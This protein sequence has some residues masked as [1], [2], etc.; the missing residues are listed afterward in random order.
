MNK[1]IIKAV[2]LV[3]VFLV[4]LV[5]LSL[6]TDTEQVDL[7]SE[8]QEPT[9]PVVCLQKGDTYINE[10]F[11]YKGTMN[12][13][14]VRDTITPLA[15]NMVLPVTIQ[16]YDN[17]IEGISYEVRTLDM[18]RL[19][20]ETQIADFIQTD[21][22]IS[23]EFQI[24]NLLEKEQEYMLIITLECNREK[25]HYY[26]RVICAEDWHV[27]DAIAFTLDFHEKTF[28]KAAASELATYL[29]PSSEGDNTTLQ[30]V[31]IHSSL[32]QITWGD[33]QG[34]VLEKPVPSI[35][36][37]GSSFQTIVLQYV[38]ASNGENGETEFYNVEEYYRLRY[39]SVNNRMLLLN[40]ERTM[41][42]IFRGSGDNFTG[43]GLRLGIREQDVSYMANENATIISFVQEG[44]LWSYNS[45]NNQLSLVYSFRGIEGMEKRTNNQNHDVRIIKVSES[46]GIDFVVY[47]YMNRGEREGCTGIGVYHYDSIANTIQEELFVQSGDAYQVLKETWGKLFYVSGEGYFYMR[48]EGSLYRI[49]LTDGA[50]KL[51][52]TGLDEENFAVSRD[53][54]YVAWRDETN[55][56]IVV[57]DLEGEEQWQIPA[58]A[59]E[60]LRP[61]GFVES[62]FVYGIGSDGENLGGRTLLKKIVI[63]DKN[64][65]VIKEYEKNGYYITDAYV[66][67]STVFLKRVWKDGTFYTQVEGDAIKSHEIEAARSIR[68]ETVA[69]EPKQTQ[70]TLTTDHE[71]SRKVPQVLTPKEVVVEKK[72]VAALDITPEEKNYYVYSGGKVMLCTKKVEEAVQCADTYAGVVLGDKQEYIWNRGRQ[73]SVSMADAVILE[74]EELNNVSGLMARSLTALLQKERISFDVGGLVDAGENPQR[75]LQEAMPSAR[76]LNL[77]GC[78][79]T[80]VLYYVNRGSLV[81]AWGENQEP[82]LIVGYDELNT[83]LY[84]PETNTTYK[85]GIQDSEEFFAAAGNVFISYL[86]E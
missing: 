25:I 75:I 61:I 22:T 8:M 70:V 77:T 49:R 39:S 74:Q 62:D 35:K 46:G 55:G 44:D 73:T 72:N 38:V 42:E 58:G 24:Q 29:E 76:V 64:Q 31:T 19:L 81:F 7:T 9:L 34:E 84:D 1:K 54:R 67:N 53:G 63:A 65:Q 30:K 59:A 4:S 66:E 37:I 5:G 86:R 20:E 28:D 69:S 10:L 51:L 60:V 50:V 82:L 52:Q 36:E 71:F 85:K 23:T 78:S 45:G 32:N 21:G 14:S 68:V 11:G 17:H 40:Y 56:S 15:K 79:V 2:V 3:L 18:E 27:D 80:Q 33:F 47:G 16:A 43:T 6:M 13:S 26:T 41:N 83:I 48:A 12:A 57:T